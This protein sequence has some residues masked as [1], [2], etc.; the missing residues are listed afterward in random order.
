VQLS[1]VPNKFPI[2][3][4]NSA[5]SGYIRAIPETSQ[6]GV[7][8]GAA[9]LTD[10]FPP[11]NFLPVGS[12]G[13]PPF[14][15]DMNGILN[16]ITLWS[17][18][19]G[20]GGLCT[21]DSVFSAAIGGYPQNAMLASSSTPGQI[22]VNTVDNN[23]SNPDAS[24]TGWVGLNQ[25]SVVHAGSDSSGSGNTVTVATVSPAISAV[26]TNMIFE[27][28]KGTAGN[29]SAS[30]VATIFGQAGTVLWA[31]GS[32]L[33]SGDWPAN[34]RAL[35]VWDGTNY[36]ILSA[37]A[38]ATSILPALTYTVNGLIPS[39]MS[40]TST[41]GSMTISSGA[42]VDKTAAS[43]GISGSS[44]SWSVTNGNAANGYQ[45]GT[46]LPNSSTI[47]MF[48]IWG[49]SGTAS[50][51][52][53]SQT[54][55]LPSGYSYYRMIFAFTTSSSGA[56]N[57]FTAIESEGGAVDCFLSTPV[58]DM[59]GFAVT[60]SQQLVTLSVPAGI[61]VEWF[62]NVAAIGSAPGT[63]LYIA[64]NSPLEA[65]IALTSGTEPNGLPTPD[66][67]IATSGNPG[68]SEVSSRK[69]IT[70]TSAQLA[71]RANQSFTG[72]YGTTQGWRFA[73]RV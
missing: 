16:Q 39:A 55:T 48:L 15:Q 1:Q 35:L 61:N 56:P 65:N 17:Q 64:F 4:G 29:T 7:Q 50:F 40:G 43:T 2:P 72:L 73:R 60:T 51:A 53:T 54:P 42:C 22:W 24:G 37:I 3:W 14:G 31:D 49:S 8:N 28:K 70:N 71:V 52:S 26:Q 66:L 57:P 69:R 62:G 67:W 11:L 6:I 33:V 46:T 23:T 13:V 32:S 59:N 5:G 34:V 45:G 10:G 63:A 47:F 44:L 38:R 58:L 30:C 20:A 18:W 36:R 68:G 27:V 19:Q 41:T 12:G 25:A 21:Y 9:S